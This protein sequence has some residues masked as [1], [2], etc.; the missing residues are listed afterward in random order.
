MPIARLGQMYM[1]ARVVWPCSWVSCMVVQGMTQARATASGA[2]RHALAAV[3]E[4]PAAV[5][6][7]LFSGWTGIA[8]AAARLSRAPGA[9]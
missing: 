2:I 9:A 8:L 4:V 1:Q 7:G 6:A 5:R 3:D